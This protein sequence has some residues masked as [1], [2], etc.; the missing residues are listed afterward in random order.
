MLLHTAA[1]ALS[2]SFSFLLPHYVITD[3]NPTP[4]THK[5]RSSSNVQSSQKKPSTSKKGRPPSRSSPIKRPHVNYNL[6]RKCPHP[7]ELE[8]QF[9]RQQGHVSQ[10]QETALTDTFTQSQQSVD[11]LASSQQ[12]VPSSQ[13]TGLLAQIMQR[14]KQVSEPPLPE[15]D[16]EET[17]SNHNDPVTDENGELVQ[18]PPRRRFS[19]DL[20]SSS[21]CSKSNTSKSKSTGSTIGDE[22]NVPEPHAWNPWDESFAQSA[23][24]FPLPER[25]KYYLKN[26]VINAKNRKV[27]ELVLLCEAARRVI[28]E[29]QM[30]AEEKGA[31]LNKIYLELIE[32]LPIE[33]FA[34]DE[35]KANMLY[36]MHGSQNPLL[37]MHGDSLFDKYKKHRTAIRT[38]FA[39][40]GT[41]FTSMAS[42]KQLHQ[43]YN[44]HIASIYAD[45]H[46]PTYNRMDIRDVIKKVP[47][48][49]W[50]THKNCLYVLTVMCHRHNN[51]FTTDTGKESSVTVAQ[52]RKSKA[53]R[54][55]E[56]RDDVKTR[57]EDQ[58]RK[59]RAAS[60]TKELDM[61]LKQRMVEDIAKTG[62][63]KR[64]EKKL[65]LLEKYKSYTSDEVYTS[66]VNKCMGQ[67]FKDD[68][69]PE[70]NINDDVNNGDDVSD[71]VNVGNEDGN[72]VEDNNN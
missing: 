21:N 15:V 38:I 37:P 54:R 27:V 50:L 53:K 16:G 48:D 46:K 65:A 20:S 3:G 6:S 36:R 5:K 24:D 2:H 44:E 66:R 55:D 69:E 34:D 63:V 18:D 32:S 72:D 47:S 8:I 58:I 7:T 12:T 14:G 10:S 49:F 4:S 22:S 33:M 35:V 68:D 70:T 39:N 52:Q 30:R 40:L 13:P 28:G 23:S 45:V 29:G 51:E 64:I 62:E 56:E 25:I 41:D 57:A 9:A 60:P 17:F 31:L 71:E 1:S 26:R 59:M 42:G 19:N 11:L 61:K 43:V 67:L